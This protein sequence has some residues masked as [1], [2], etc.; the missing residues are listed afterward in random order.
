MADPLTVIAGAAAVGGATGKLVEKTW[1]AGEK[2]LS[3]YFADHSDQALE[4][5]RD[6][7]AQFLVDLSTRMKAVEDRLR[8]SGRSTEDI[9]NALEDPDLAVTMR[10]ALL[11]SAR[12]SDATKHDLLARAI[13]ERLGAEPESVRALATPLAINAIPHL[14]AGQIE[15]LGIAAIV[16]GIRPT[17]YPN[18]LPESEIPEIFGSW[19]HLA[20]RS[21][22]NA[23]VPAP[24]DFWHLV[25]TNCLIFL[26]F[27]GRELVGALGE[28]LPTSVAPSIGDFVEKSDAGPRLK[29]VW[30]AGLQSVDL[31]PVGRVIG[32]TVHDRDIGVVTELDW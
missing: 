11:A 18:K 2:W 7:T 6:N 1:D 12:T 8:E 5:A 21:F 24:M 28:G 26:P 27:V 9:R 30:E 10:S 20:F 13:A 4:R 31:T 19:L 3:R 29:Q 32:T 22:S 25:S 15:L 16:Y 14:T 17:W 23:S